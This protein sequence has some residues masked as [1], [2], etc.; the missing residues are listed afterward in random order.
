ML[1]VALDGSEDHLGRGDAARLWLEADMPRKRAAALGDVDARW[2]VGVLTWDNHRDL[3]ASFPHR[4]QLDEYVE[5]QEDEG[6][7]PMG[8]P[9][10]D[11][12]DVSGDSEDAHAEARQSREIF[13]TD[14][15]LVQVGE[16]SE[17]LRKS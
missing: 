5:G 15:Q 13:M 1:S 16:I 14:D 3:V 7:A 10:T 9:W 4:G 17:R 12:E 8:A 2:S 11:R 6:E